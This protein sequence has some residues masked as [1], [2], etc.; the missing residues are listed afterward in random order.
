[1]C[2]GEKG[3]TFCFIREAPVGQSYAKSSEIHA[4]DTPASGNPPNR[5]IHEHIRE[6]A[7]HGNT[8]CN[9]KSMLALFVQWE[10]ESFALFFSFVVSANIVFT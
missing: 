3:T 10:R 7:F 5:Y 6:P 8:R 1:V 9:D 2:T 4:I